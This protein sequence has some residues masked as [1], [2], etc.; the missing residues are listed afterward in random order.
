MADT[1]D[2][3]E[4]RSAYSR[5][6][7]LKGGAFVAAAGALASGGLLAGCSSEQT[8]SPASEAKTTASGTSY[9]VYQD[10]IIIVGGGFGATKAAFRALEKGMHV[11]IVDKSM[12]GRSGGFGFNWDVQ[13]GF[14]PEKGA[15]QNWL[16]M[17][18][19]GSHDAETMV[20]IL[21]A[22]DY[23]ENGINHDDLL[24]INQGACLPVRNDDGS[25]QYWIDMPSFK[26]MNGLFPRPWA[27]LL[28]A[29]PNVTVFNNTMATDLLVNDGRCVGVIGLDLETGRIKVMRAK[30]VLAATGPTTWIYGWNTVAAYTIGSPDNTGD[31]DMAAY[32]RGCGIGESEFAGFD[33]QSCY[34]AGLS[35]GYNTAFNADAVETD[36]FADKDGNLM[37]TPEICE[38]EG[39][40]IER[41]NY[42]R[43]YINAILAE[44]MLAGAMD[45]DGCL[46]ANVRDAES[47][48]DST[49]RNIEFL[50]ETWGI[51]PLNDFIPIHDETYERGGTPV[52]DENDMTEIPGFFTT[53]GAGVGCGHEGGS[54]MTLQHFHGRYAMDRV[55][56]YLDS[57]DPIEEIDWTPVG[58]EIGR[59]YDILNAEAGDGIRPH[60]LR[61]RIQKA[62]ETCYGMVRQGDKMPAA[63]EEIE[64]IRKEDLPRQVVTNH[65]PVW[66]REWKEA[67]ENYNLLDA[68]ELAL[69]ASYMREET[70]GNYYRADFPEASEDWNCMLVATKNGEDIEWEKRVMPT[71]DFGN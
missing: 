21:E 34:P 2:S 57:A 14:M 66:N 1:F 39:I 36:M 19:D 41:G 18:N 50:Q 58:K 28:K 49:K 12:Y 48:R 9:D 10:E 33:F 5:R 15:A 65:S 70:R 61:H 63:I 45:D 67:I 38:A 54:M 4:S 55:I 6:S 60:E 29:N 22:Y 37:F 17:R 8:Q 53:R 46:R 16:Y 26:S 30:A 13:G 43:P 71:H 27:D 35:C 40:D 11:T 25:I 47:L 20:K 7:F 44:K 56:E 3:H 23:D 59:L 64:R 42:D 51:D 68:A 24:H 62:V 52:V 32:R 69:K 31:L